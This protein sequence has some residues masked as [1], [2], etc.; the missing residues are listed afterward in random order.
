MNGGGIAFENVMTGDGRVWTDGAW[1]WENPADIPVQWNPDDNSSH[2]GTLTFGAI[3]SITRVG[4][5]LEAEGT[6]DDQLPRADE[7]VA[8]MGQG[9]ATGVS[10]VF[11]DVTVE[12]VDNTP[13][14]GQDQPVTIMASCTVRIDHEGL[15]VVEAPDTVR[16]LLAAAGDPAPDGE[17]LFEDAS[18]SVVF[19]FTRSR[20]RALTL[21]DVPAFVDARIEL[22]DEAVTEPAAGPDGQPVASSQ[23]PAIAASATA[24]LYPPASWF[25]TP[26]PPDDSPLWVEQVGGVYAVPLTITDEGEVYGH[27][28]FWG[29]CHVGYLEGCVSPPVSDND[30]MSR[31]L[32]LGSAGE[33]IRPGFLTGVTRVAEG[34]D[35]PT[36]PLVMMA[37]HPDAWLFAAQARDE[38]AHTGLAWA[39]VTAVQTP[40]GVWV[41]GA[42]RPEVTPEQLRVLRASALSGDWR[43]VPPYD[44]P[45]L[46]AVLTVSRPGFPIARTQ[47]AAHGQVMTM[48]PPRALVQYA[49]DGRV[50]RASGV[51]VVR[52]LCPSCLEGQEERFSLGLF[53]EE[54][55]RLLRAL[56][57]RTRHQRP[58]AASAALERIRVRNDGVRVT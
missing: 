24:P 15:H 6:L 41:R 46:I 19:R 27:A 4:N 7:L 30:F 25:A 23:E 12:V 58:V 52:H 50:V 57:V 18:D 16:A 31:A 36:A 40:S 29:Q 42:V 11:D 38:Y 39:D 48:P 2:E 34:H 20:I 21:V 10:V 3:D 53:E 47:L 51:N 17:V 26:E 37:D 56:E 33:L 55:L 1:T 13:G 44:G 43:E 5:A 28:C 35:V 32:E 22:T 8:R 45:Q 49:E 54:A 14:G 9:L